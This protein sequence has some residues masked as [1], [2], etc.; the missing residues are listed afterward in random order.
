MARTKLEKLSKTI[1]EAFVE[2]LRTAFKARWRRNLVTQ[3]N[4]LAMAMISRPANG[5]PFTPAQ[6]AWVDGF[7]AGY[8]EAGDIV[9]LTAQDEV[10]ARL[11]KRLSNQGESK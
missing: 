2:K 1:N 3:Y 5:K 11:T 4:I 9:Y 7:E 10:D 6:K 8:T